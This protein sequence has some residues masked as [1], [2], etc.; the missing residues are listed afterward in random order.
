M[1][2]GD[3]YRRIGER[4]V[5]FKL[6]VQETG[7]KTLFLRIGQVQASSDLRNCPATQHEARTTGQQQFSDFLSISFQT[8]P[9]IQPSY[10][11]NGSRMSLEMEQDKGY[12]LWNPLMYFKSGLQAYVGVSILE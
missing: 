12:L 11:G 5:G 1:E 4:I 8:S 7:P 3:S 6:T 9:A 2:L 10:P